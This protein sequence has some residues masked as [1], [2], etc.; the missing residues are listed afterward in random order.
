MNYKHSGIIKLDINSIITI[1]AYMRN[2]EGAMEDK[3]LAKKVDILKA[4]SQ[5]TRIRILNLLRNGE[6]CICK[7]VPELGEE[8]VNISKHLAILRH[9]GL[10]EFRKEGVSSYYK[11]SHKEIFKIIELAD[12][13]LRRELTKAG[14]M[15]KIDMRDENHAT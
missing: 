10:V 8:Q 7:M 9:A 14:A 13:I 1:L 12:I 6:K 15:I 3:L 11:V 4:V 5:S 2:M